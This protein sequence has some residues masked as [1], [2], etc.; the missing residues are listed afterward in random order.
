MRTSGMGCGG[1]GWGC[2]PF[3]RAGEVAGR[4]GN[5]QRE[6]EFYSIGFQSQNEG[7]E[8]GEV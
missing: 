2:G 4:T 5:G 8:G 1:G 3:Y 6:F 7:R